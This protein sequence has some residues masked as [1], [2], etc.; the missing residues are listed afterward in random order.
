M[1]EKFGLY[2]KA[3][4]AEFLQSFL[5][6]AHFV[7]SDA[8]TVDDCCDPPSLVHDNFRLNLVKRMTCKCDDTSVDQRYDVNYF[9]HYITA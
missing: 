3:D 8:K 7:F 9:N 4:A 6:L 2:Q 5:E 1:N